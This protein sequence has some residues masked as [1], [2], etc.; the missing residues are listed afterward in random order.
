MDG[1]SVYLQEEVH[2]YIFGQSQATMPA[3]FY[4]ALSTSPFNPDDTGIAEPSGGD[5]AR[6]DAPKAI[7]AAPGTS[8]YITTTQNT[9]DITFAESTALWGEI[10][11]FGAYS[12]VTGG[13]LIFGGGLDTFKTIETATIAVFSTGDL[14]L[15]TKNTP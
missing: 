2:K 8:G 3:T 6:K 1:Y 9:S 5:Y 14:K 12:A 7:F 13:D 15:S 11:A 4:I 10:Q